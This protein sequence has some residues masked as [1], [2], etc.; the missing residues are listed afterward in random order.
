MELHSFHVQLEAAAAVADSNSIHNLLN[1]V[2]C[3]DYGDFDEHLAVEPL[4]STN[5]PKK[6]AFDDRKVDT[7]N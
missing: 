2:C 7:H 4:L 3:V 5:Q 1:R 6:I